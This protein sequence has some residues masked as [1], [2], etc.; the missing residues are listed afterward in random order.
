ME[1][2][3]LITKNIYKDDGKCA[4]KTAPFKRF[5]DIS[6]GE[7]NSK[8]PTILLPTDYWSLWPDDHAQEAW[9]QFT[10]SLARFLGTDVREVSL[11]VL[12]KQTDHGQNGEAL[13]DYL[14]HVSNI[15]TS[16]NS[17]T[18]NEH[19]CDSVKRD[20][21]NQWH[22]EVSMCSVRDD[23]LHAMGSS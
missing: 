11:T 14:K 7:I 1:Q 22:R 3:G 21:P 5:S 15:P 20:L 12:W 9:R 18:A 10:T 2:L 19:T 8:A 23:P 17:L 6:S 13:G 4:A 16:H